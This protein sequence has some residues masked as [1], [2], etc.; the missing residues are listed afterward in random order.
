MTK[1]PLH[2]RLGLSTEE[3]LNRL[4]S[5]RQCAHRYEKEYKEKMNLKFLVAVLGA[6]TLKENT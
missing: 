1:Q 2:E 6:N 5:I 3:T 4:I